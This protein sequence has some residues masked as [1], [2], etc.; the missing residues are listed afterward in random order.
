MKYGLSLYILS[1]AVDFK[2]PTG[3][4]KHPSPIFG[5]SLSGLVMTLKSFVTAFTVSLRYC[6]RL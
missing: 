3:L 2:A 6:I 1:A 5:P 4:E